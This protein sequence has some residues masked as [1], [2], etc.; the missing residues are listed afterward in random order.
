MQLQCIW[1]FNAR[2]F[3]GLIERSELGNKLPK[4]R[5][6]LNI[7]HSGFGVLEFY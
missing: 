7:Q 5:D 3:K 2:I 6:L 4:L 1:N